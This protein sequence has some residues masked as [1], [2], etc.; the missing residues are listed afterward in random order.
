MTDQPQPN[1]PYRDDEID[2]RKLFQAIGNFFVNIGRSIIRLILAVR[3]ATL[4]YK[5]LLITAVI[6][7]GLAGL[8]ANKVFDPYYNTQ[9]VLRSGYLNTQLVQN[10]IDKLNLLCEEETKEGLALTLGIPLEVAEN[11]HEFSFEPFVAENDIVEIELLKQRLEELKIEN[12][13]I[14]KVIQQID[15]KNRNSFVISVQVYDTEII[16]NLQDALLDY[17][18]NNPYIANRIRTNKARLEQLIVKLTQ[19]VAML[20]SLKNAYN[21]NLKAQGERKGPEASNSFFLGE[22]GAVNPVSVYSQGVSLFQQLQSA[23]VSL[24]LG[25]DFELVDGFTTF[26]KPDSPGLLKSIVLMA[27]I[28]LGLA[29]LLIILIEI[30]RYLNRVEEQGFED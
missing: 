23:K 10:S 5:V 29:Y 8:T 12:T 7:G 21:F 16:A 2:L 28:F 17:F 30:N 22:S 1:Q 20:D 11:I 14:D 25:S 3:R 19:E 15:I 27:G 4:R 26:S 24:E 9:L 18:K 13:D 6:I